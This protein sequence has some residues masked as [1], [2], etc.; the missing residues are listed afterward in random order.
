MQKPA[1][2]EAED[3]NKE[4]DAEE[5]AEEEKE[6]EKDE[7]DKEQEQ[8]ADDDEEVKGTQVR[9]YAALVGCCCRSAQ[10]PRGSFEDWVCC[11]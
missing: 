6:E 7:E 9:S 5:E 8:E 2:N 10:R 4:G 11:F 3:E 1:S